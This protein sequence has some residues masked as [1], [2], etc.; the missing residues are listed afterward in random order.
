M[1]RLIRA[2]FRK[3]STRFEDREFS[4]PVYEQKSGKQRIE[5]TVYLPEVDEESVELAIENED[6]VITAKRRPFLRTNFIAMQLEKRLADYRLRARL[7]AGIRLKALKA[8][9][10]DGML[11]IVLPTEHIARGWQVAVS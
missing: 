7:G 8:E 11:R 5:L 1:K 6:L 9:I 3:S 4:K 10:V 2:I